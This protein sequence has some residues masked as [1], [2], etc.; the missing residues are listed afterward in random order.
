[1]SYEVMYWLGFVLVA[2]LF[3][4]WLSAAIGFAFLV[5]SCIAVMLGS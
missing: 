3:P 1:M 5:S 4:A 2:R